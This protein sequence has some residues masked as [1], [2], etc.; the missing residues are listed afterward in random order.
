MSQVT[1]PFPALKETTV[2]Q[3][4][5]IV[6]TALQQ[7]SDDT[8]IIEVDVVDLDAPVINV[9]RSIAIIYSKDSMP[10]TC[11]AAMLRNQV[12]T[13][14]IGAAKETYKVDFIEI[15]DLEIEEIHDGYLWLGMASM[16]PDMHPN[17]ESKFKEAQHSTIEMS[18]K[19]ECPI[20]PSPFRL[21]VGEVIDVMGQ[22]KPD[23]DFMYRSMDRLSSLIPE[24]DF[25]QSWK[26]LRE[27]NELES[28]VGEFLS[29]KGTTQG[30]ITAWVIMNRCLRE[31]GHPHADFSEDIT[32]EGL[33][34]LYLQHRSTMKAII[35][36]SEI[37]AIS[38][39]GK[40]NRVIG[41][42]IPEGF[43]MARRIIEVTGAYYHNVRL[44]KT[45]Y[46]V[47]ANL[48]CNIAKVFKLGSSRSSS[49]H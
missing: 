40:V 13:R 45:G 2:N 26:T 27:L 22:L 23:Y 24:M 46:H 31:L 21:A 36:K 41:T 44:T 10:S 43:W 42:S 35:E 9:K 19:D 39:D 38:F 4:T 37:T 18:F 7:H 30:L 28:S 20:L 15:G 1:F 48:P 49:K 3:Y 5:E 25:S 16:V 6:K 11:A 33:M 14:L 34:E 8:E 29:G 32:A 12:A 47:E 17:L